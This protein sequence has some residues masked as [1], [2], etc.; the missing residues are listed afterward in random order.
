MVVE[1]ILEWVGSSKR[2]LMNFP[3]DVRRAMGYA[4]GV[5]QLGAK[6]PSAKP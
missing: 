4:L 5:A 1:K 2:D 3:E 6:H